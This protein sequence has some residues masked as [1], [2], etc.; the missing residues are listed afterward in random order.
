[1]LPCAF[2]MFAMHCIGVRVAAQS[3]GRSSISLS[4]CGWGRA[5]LPERHLAPVPLAR[6][7]RVL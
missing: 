7:R 4:R 1:M 5:V 3:R 6:P 2:L